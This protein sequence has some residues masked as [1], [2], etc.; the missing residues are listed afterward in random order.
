MSDGLLSLINKGGNRTQAIPSNSSGRSI[1]ITNLGNH[2]LIKEPTIQGHKKY[3][4]FSL[5]ALSILAGDQVTKHLVLESIPLGTGYEVIPGFLNVVHVRNSGAAFG[6]G[7]GWGARFFLVVSVTALL[8]ILWLLASS[9]ETR[10]VLVAGYGLFFGG[11][12]GNFLD[13][14][15]FGEVIDFLDLHVGTWHWPAFN[16]A[17]SALCIGAACFFIYYLMPLRVPEDSD[18]NVEYSS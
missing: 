5:I 6:M 18:G 11:V 12:L 14:I 7:S 15:R 16:V 17:D 4:L 3:I 13:R 2:H 9:K 10:L 8:T 1:S